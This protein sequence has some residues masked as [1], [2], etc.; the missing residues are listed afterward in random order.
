M[1]ELTAEKL[2]Q[3][4]YTV[5]IL[6]EQH[7]SHIW[8]T[9]GSHNVPA[10]D[11]VQVALR[12]EYLT[13]YQVERLLKGDRGG[14][15]YGDYKVHY[16][17]GEGSFARVFRAVHKDT[18]Q[19]VALKVLRSRFS[20]NLEQ[21]SRFLQ[22]GQVGMTLRHPN[23]VPTYEVY[24]KGRTHFLVMEFVEGQNLRE[25]VHMRGRLKTDEAVKLGTDIAAGLAYALE[26]GMT[27][28]DLK[29]TN[30]LVSSRG[31]AKLVDFGL[32]GIEDP[33]DDSLTNARTV[34]Y[35]ALERIT[36]VQK[37]DPR[38]DVYFY[39]CILYGMLA[40]APP[41]AETRDRVQRMSRERF[42]AVKPIQTVVADLHPAVT[43]IVNKAMTLDPE[44]RYQT[45]AAI[46][47][48]LKQAAR[49]ML[50][51]N[52]DGN[53]DQ[54][55]ALA[56]LAEK[57]DEEHSVMIVESNVEMQ[58]VFR[59]ALKKAGFRVLLTADPARALDRFRRDPATAECLVFNTRELGQ[60]AVDAFNNLADDEK[61]SSVPAILLLDE[62]F[63]EL[64]TGLRTTEQR[65]MLQMPCTM[66]K[67]RETMQALVQGR[68]APAK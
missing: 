41:L 17:V 12:R 30:V 15:F 43:L 59:T 62:R 1:S 32:V 31:Q 38:S 63:K 57:P 29:M 39:G 44:R 11:F 49:R 9:L 52:R 51:E 37:D 3:R 14:Y 53:G 54:R 47:A 27:H 42:L 10:A 7:L 67:L 6:D 50:Q 5:G 25:F 19:I 66:K 24:S 61:T 45:P 23:V 28:R 13:N 4:A 21:Y 55:S 36:G 8:S 16:C 26:F 18:G 22:E 46:V 68:S 40:G 60:E 64:K 56:A 33:A 2:A 34:D 20:D 58:D 35:A 48:D 65:V